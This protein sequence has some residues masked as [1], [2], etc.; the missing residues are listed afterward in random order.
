MQLHQPR[1]HWLFAVGVTSHCIKMVA[2]TDNKKELESQE[3]QGVGTLICT[4]VTA[5]TGVKKF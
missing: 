5:K 4:V 2:V 1:T 3:K